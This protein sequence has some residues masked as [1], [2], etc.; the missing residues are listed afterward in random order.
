MI[1]RLIPQV[2]EFFA[3]SLQ[4]YSYNVP[5]NPY[6]W[7]GFLWGAQLP[8]FLI[9][10]IHFLQNNSSYS[11]TWSLFS[12]TLQIFCFSYPILLGAIFGILGTIRAEK[13]LQIKELITR[14]Q[15]TSITDPL[16]GLYNR[17][18]F[19]SIFHTLTSQVQR[20]NK[21]ISILFIDIDD[22]K[23]IND[24]FGHS[25]GDQ[26]LAQLSD[27]LQ[28]SL[29]PYDLPVRWGG[30][31]FLLLLPEVSEKRAQ[32]IADRLRKKS[33]AVLSARFS[34]KITLSIGVASYDQQDTLDSFVDKA[35]QSLYAAKVLGKNQVVSWS[36]VQK[37]K[38]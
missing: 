22:F 30:E 24:N 9:F 27:I 14:L 4:A 17:R 12:P 31:E 38:A 6:I 18:H 32:E 20:S 11:E 8:V 36:A 28:E 1:Y 2:K 10:L 26:V 15:Q 33:M 13:A 23:S 29:R 7:F 34:L 21:P 3:A 25:T 16:T 5:K 19:T 37:G 35:D